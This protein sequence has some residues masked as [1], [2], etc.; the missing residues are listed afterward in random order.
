MAS[1]FTIAASLR[2]N[3][4]ALR[5]SEVTSQSSTTNCD[6]SLGNRTVVT[7]P[8]DRSIPSSARVSRLY[9]WPIRLMSTKLKPTVRNSSAAYASK[10]TFM[11]VKMNIMKEII[12]TI[13][14]ASLTTRPQHGHLLTENSRR[15]TIILIAAIGLL[16]LETTRGDQ[17]SPTSHSKKKPH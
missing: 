13:P 16:L 14:L 15:W 4:L 5:V 3:T 2:K 11:K 10:L 17:T 12:I 8:E 1:S 9:P 7:I 6:A